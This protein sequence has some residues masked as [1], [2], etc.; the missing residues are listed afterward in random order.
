[1]FMENRTGPRMDPCG[2]PE[3][4]LA[5]EEERSSIMTEIM[6]RFTGFCRKSV[7][8]NVP[9]ICI[10]DIKYNRGLSV[11]LRPCPQDPLPCMILI[12]PC[13]MD[14]CESGVLE[15]GNT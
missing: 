15:K 3:V 12:F 14:L 11:F 4:R 5:E 6:T 8:S 10:V 1:M 9:D 7:C 13:L 2:T